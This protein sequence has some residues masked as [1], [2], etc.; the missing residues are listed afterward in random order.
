MLTMVF[1]SVTPIDSL[2]FATVV[3]VP[4]SFSLAIV[5][6]VLSYLLGKVRSVSPP[7]SNYPIAVFNPLPFR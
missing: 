4:L 7:L 1:M 3:I 6:V 5:V 2:V